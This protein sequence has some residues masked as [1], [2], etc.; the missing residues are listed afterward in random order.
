VEQSGAIVL[1]L[2]DGTVRPAPF[3]DLT[4]K[5][6]RL[7][8]EFDERGLLGMA[9]HPQ[10]K[11]NGK[12]YVV[13]SGPV[14][15]DTPRRVRLNF[16]CTNYLSEFRVSKTDPNQA[17]LATERIIYRWHKPQFNHNG[18]A[19]AFG[20]DGYLYIATGDGGSANDK[21]LFHTEKIGNA[22]DLKSPLGKIL[23]INVNAGDPYSIPADNPF[24]DSKDALPEIYAYGLRNPWRMSFDAG[25]E[26]Q[27]FTA[28]VGQNAYEEVDIIVKGA[29][30]GWNRME[31]TRCF[32]P[33]DPNKPPETCNKSGLT[34]PIA[35]YGNLNVV[36]DGKGLSVTGGYVYRGKAIPQ[37]QG[38]YVFGD[39]SRQFIQPEGVLLVAFPPKEKGAMW[40]IEDVEVVNMKF[41]SY[42]LAFA[43]DEDNELYVLTSDNT[44]PTRGVDK[45]YKIVPAD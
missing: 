35:E 36:K 1:L 26:H 38:T 42:V 45:I 43:Q 23:R 37:L 41:H 21:A 9:F 15:S 32:N 39:W 13:Y 33:D 28:D 7:N 31:G 30:Y 25:G 18:G 44:A 12:F 22:Q 29:N 4:D 5:M 40:A 19:I 17:D 27:L 2:P 34:M 24:A 14:S 11:E 6:V 10:F 16:N 20:P 3:L 8:R